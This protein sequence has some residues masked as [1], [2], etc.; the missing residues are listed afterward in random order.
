MST[1]D[2]LEISWFAA[3]CDDDYEF[4]GVPD[5]SLQSSWEHCKKI[6]LKAEEQGFDNI[7]LPSG[8][9][10]GIDGTSFAAAIAS[11]TKKIRLLLAVRTGEVWAPQLA[12]QIASIDQIAEGRLDINI[13]SS[14]LP[15]EKIDSKERYE[16]TTEYM[17]VLR[18]LL[19][20][21]DID[22]QGDFIKLQISPPRIRTVS[23]SC[24]AYYFGGFSEN[25]K[26][27]AAA[28]A[29]VFLTWPDTVT[30]VEKTIKEMTDRSAKKGRTLKYGLRSHVIV[31]ETEEEARKAAVQLVSKLD[32]GVGAEI[33][34]RSLD[35][36]SVGVSR[37]IELRQSSDQDGFVEE[38]LW[39]GIGRARSGAGAAIVG[40]PDQVVRK[41]RE[42][43]Q[44]G[45]EAF[46]FSGYPHIEE[47]EKFGQLVLPHLTHHSL[48]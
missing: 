20:G 4:L 1:H 27:V 2:S 41:I 31:R 13:I 18:Q 12:R 48:T 28:E 42:Y 10:L 19:D 23:G 35:A 11:Q 14:D 16:R 32:D 21:Q 46:I 47:C 45:I 15:G 6:V 37:Q 25:A 34:S 7:L 38:G 8:Y 3:L 33:R 5:S 24:P 22:H 43:Q 26:E 36:S 30:E 9:Q 39:T 17:Q 40:D 44:I 29:D